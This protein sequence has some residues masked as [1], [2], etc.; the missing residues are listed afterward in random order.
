MSRY[1]IRYTLQALE[2]LIISDGS[3]IGNILTTQDY[4]P[5]STILG[6]CAGLYLREQKNL[7]PATAH[8]D[9][10]FQVLFLSDETIFS[11][12][13]PVSERGHKCFPM[14]YSVFGCKYYGFFSPE[15]VHRKMH[16]V[17]DYL[18]A[19]IPEKCPVDGC[20]DPLEHKTG[21]CYR[22][23]GQ[24]CTHE[25]GKSI[26]AHNKV[27]ETPEDK[28]LFAFETISEYQSFHGEISFSDKAQ[29]DAI[30]N[31]LLKYENV[32][33]G[34]ARR[35]GYGRVKT[36]VSKA[37]KSY[38]EE[39]SNCKVTEDDVFSIYLYSDAIIVDS[40]LNYTSCID[41]SNLASCL[42]V[43]SQDLEVYLSPPSI[44]SAT[45]KSFWKNRIVMGFNEKRRMPLPF[46]MAISKGS[47]FTVQ[48]KGKDTTKLA[49]GISKLMEDGIGLRKNEGFGQVV[50]NHWIH[51]KE[52]QDGSS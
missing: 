5:G 4:V 3:Q 29:R 24:L 34:K 52:V 47:V 28:E 33:I 48:Y 14:P 22:E 25:V 42:E 6:L 9:T 21:Y 46:E 11:P 20:S 12:A 37:D 40:T 35:R 45:Y 51:G 19:E 2:P 8:E 7:D 10:E 49:E 1:Y 31:L 43:E 39:L 18:F 17:R 36:S 41:N 32:T 15:P 30:Y 13:Y 26:I 38:R 27:G 44:D 50:V 16:G 23:N